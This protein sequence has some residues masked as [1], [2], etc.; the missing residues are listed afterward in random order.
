MVK[1]TAHLPQETKWP[2]GIKTNDLSWSQQIMQRFS[3]LVFWESLSSGWISWLSGLSYPESWLFSSIICCS[4]LAFRDSMINFSDFSDMTN[5]HP[6]YQTACSNQGSSFLTQSFNPPLQLKHTT[7]SPRP[8]KKIRDDMP[9]VQ[10]VLT[11]YLIKFS[12]LED[13]II[14][15]YVY[16]KLFVK[17]QKMKTYRMVQRSCPQRQTP[18]KSEGTPIDLTN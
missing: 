5:R 4:N 6:G 3:S 16:S 2:Q 14:R 12:A 1:L 8:V 15:S 9:D 13:T 10:F 18:H 7:L 17:N 11:Y